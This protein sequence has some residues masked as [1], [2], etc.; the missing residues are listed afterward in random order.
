MKQNK[1]A[2]WI[3]GTAGVAFSAFVLSQF[4]P[5]QTANAN[6]TGAQQEQ[7]QNQDQNNASY[8]FS[9]RDS[10]FSN[11]SDNSAGQ[12]GGS[13]WN[14]DPSQGSQNFNQNGFTDRQSGRS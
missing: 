13:E 9:G 5:V 12:D 14:F 7:Q 1:K 8:G 6:Q 2:K 3:V 11:N 4:S 10:Q